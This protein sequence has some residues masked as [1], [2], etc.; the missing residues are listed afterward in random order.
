MLNVTEALCLCIEA[1]AG[2]VELESAFDD[3]ADSLVEAL[4]KVITH[5]AGQHH[6][7]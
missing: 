7:D 1:Q 2:D 5:N 3:R 4:V 6:A